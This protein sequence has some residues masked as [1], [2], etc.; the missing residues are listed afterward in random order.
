MPAHQMAS[1]FVF[2]ILFIFTPTKP[3]HVLSTLLKYF[4]PESKTF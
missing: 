2:Q 4:W 1:A 3:T